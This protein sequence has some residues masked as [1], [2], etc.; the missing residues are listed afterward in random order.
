M[1]QIEELPPND[2][3]VGNFTEKAGTRGQSGLLLV[4]TMRKAIYK[5]RFKQQ[6]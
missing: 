4:C 6:Q 3:E 1:T 5:Q 2:T